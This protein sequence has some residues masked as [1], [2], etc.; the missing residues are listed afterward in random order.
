[1]RKVAILL[2]VLGCLAGAA[3]QAQGS[4]RG[5]I[6]LP[7]GEPLAVTT[8]IIVSSEDPRQP[9]DYQFTD[10]KGWFFLQGIRANIR[11]S[12]TVE[13]DDQTFA[14]TTDWF[15]AGRSSFIAI[16]LLPR[17]EARSVPNSP[18]VS[19][20]QLQHKPLPKARRAYEQALQALSEQKIELA[21]SKLRQAL[22]IDPAYVNACNELGVLEMEEKRYSEAESL[23]R[24]ALRHDPNA[25]HPLMNLGITLNHLGRHREAIEPLRKTLQ[26]RPQWVTPK[27]YLGIALLETNELSEAETLLL[28]GTRTTGLEEALAFLYLGKLY[29]LKEDRDKAIA[30]W[31]SYLERDPDSLNAARVRDLLARLRSGAA[32]P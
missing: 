21:R 16:Y 24:Q 10:S 15:I 28:R 3:L 12:I 9:A 18:D 13:S 4:F 31:Q 23:L 14:T 8:R 32:K 20:K 5:R 2:V 19:S 30:A 6:F 22:E 27:V 29:V 11:Y 1:M 26:L 17:E 7:N 25:A